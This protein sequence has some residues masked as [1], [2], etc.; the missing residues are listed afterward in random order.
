MKIATTVNENSSVR[1]GARA[2]VRRWRQR[3]GIAMVALLAALVTV[4]PV[5]AYA[6]QS[7]SVI[8]QSVATRVALDEVV[9]NKVD[10]VYSQIQNGLSDYAGKLVTDLIGNRDSIKSALKP[11]LSDAIKAELDKA[12]ISDPKVDELIEKSVDKI[13]DNKYVD[14]ILDHEFTQAVIARTCR[15]ATADIIAQLNISA[16]RDTIVA[17]ASDHIW[18]A[19]LKSVGTASTKV[20]SDLPVI[21]AAGVVTNT[22]YY[23]FSV[24]SWNTLFGIKTTAKE[25]NVSGWNSSNI[26]TYITAT[27]GL[28]AAGK[29]NE[30][31]TKLSNM[32]YKTIILEAAKR[33]IYD[34]VVFRL[35]TLYQNV[36][37]CVVTNVQEELAE[38]GINVA[39]NPTDS[40]EKLAKD[41][42]AAVEAKAIQD[43][44]TALDSLW[45][46]LLS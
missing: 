41:I 39:L 15:Y 37:T 9:A 12:N 43:T 31:K 46:Y 13:I 28:N 32:D 26:N 42:K 30:Y 25:I 22:S 23:N 40:L 27:V 29:Y 4:T 11:I 20:K 18:N 6:A 5:L 2:S 16:D 7:N 21:T 38:L 35:E 8:D 36:K 3:L 17:N 45:Q 24:V 44:H 19:S 33:A 10:G 1:Q 14:M 34:E